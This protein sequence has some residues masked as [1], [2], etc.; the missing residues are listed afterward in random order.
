MLVKT[1]NFKLTFFTLYIFA[2]SLIAGC[3]KGND[4]N[5]ISLLLPL[6]ANNTEK[7]QSNETNL[8]GCVLTYETGNESISTCFNLNQKDCNVNFFLNISSEQILNKRKNDLSFLNINFSNCSN[9]GLTLVSKY[10]CLSVPSSTILNDIL[11]IKNVSELN[12]LRISNTLSCEHSKFTLESLTSNSFERLLYKD[13]LLSLNSLEI[14]LSLIQST[15][16]ACLQDLNIS[17][18]LI[19]FLSK[20]K[21]KKYLTGIPCSNS[22]ISF[23]GKCQN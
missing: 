1:K 5:Q 9:S 8:N 10:N 21:D 11:N 16:L 18:D 2:F 6:L 13:E 22:T 12:N 4:P 7:L 19:N 15:T 14:E 23:F 3:I 17:N 20:I